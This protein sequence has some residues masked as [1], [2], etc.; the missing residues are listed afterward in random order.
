M[1][2]YNIRVHFNGMKVREVVTV[3]A[4]NAV[5]AHSEVWPKLSKKSRQLVDT[6]EILSIEMCAHKKVV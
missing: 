2:D 1:K 3:C 6:F 5:D 4:S